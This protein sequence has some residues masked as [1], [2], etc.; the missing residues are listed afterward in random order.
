MC[1]SGRNNHQAVSILQLARH[2]WK[3][4]QAVLMVTSEV[5]SG[6]MQVLPRSRTAL[7]AQKINEPRLN[8]ISYIHG[9]TAPIEMA[10]QVS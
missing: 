8:S 10:L 4:K 6:H 2:L 1:Y 7:Q 5:L 9:N 3:A